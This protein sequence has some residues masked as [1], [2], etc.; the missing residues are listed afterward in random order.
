MQ[1]SFKNLGV[2][3]N[4]IKNLGNTRGVPKKKDKLEGRRRKN[5]PSNDNNNNDVNNSGDIPDGSPTKTVVSYDTNDTDTSTSSANN[6]KSSLFLPY[7]LGK[8]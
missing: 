4:L 3:K 5:V 7:F 2:F 6:I 8:S 1:A